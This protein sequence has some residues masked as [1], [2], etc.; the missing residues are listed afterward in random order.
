MTGQASAGGGA[1]V[2]HTFTDPA[3][4]ATAPTPPAYTFEAAPRT[5]MA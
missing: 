1:A 5:V 4:T 2:G 3:Y